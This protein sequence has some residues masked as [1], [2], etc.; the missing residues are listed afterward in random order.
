MEAIGQLAAGVAHD[1]NNLLTVI[2]G[3]TEL[4][5]NQLE[6]AH[7]AHADLQEVLHAG[8]SAA[9]LT[10]QLLAFSRRQMLQ[11]QILT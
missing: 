10:T 5:L 6:P 4:T 2:M 3:F 11:P 9:A 1:F 8:R 7:P